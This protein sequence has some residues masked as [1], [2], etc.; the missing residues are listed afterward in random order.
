MVREMLSKIFDGG[1]DGVVFVPINVDGDLQ[2]NGFEYKRKYKPILA[3]MG[4]FYHI[5]LYKA[6]HLGEVVDKDYFTA[7]LS[8]PK[9]YVANLIQSDF[10]GVV[11]KQTKGSKKFIKELYKKILES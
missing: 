4:H 10:Y 5:I 6:N 7:V 1:S 11:V 8:D 9:V 2:I 3:N